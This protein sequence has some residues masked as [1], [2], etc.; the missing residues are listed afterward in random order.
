MVIGMCYFRGC[1]SPAMGKYCDEHD[2][3]EKRERADENCFLE[4]VIGFLKG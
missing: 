1:G 3:R 4:R 2:S